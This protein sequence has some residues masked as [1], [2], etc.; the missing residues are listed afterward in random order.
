M[1]GHVDEGLVRRHMVCPS[2]RAESWQCR[3]CTHRAV[4]DEN[5]TCKTPAPC[6]GICKPVTED[7]RPGYDFDPY[8]GE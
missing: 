8:G 5:M 7:P 1:V 4:H 6:G 2:F 3:G